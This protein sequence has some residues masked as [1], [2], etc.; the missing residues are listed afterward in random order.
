M[1]AAVHRF[2]ETSTDFADFRRFVPLNLCKSGPREHDVPGGR[3]VDGKAREGE[4]S[5]S[6]N[7]SVEE[8]SVLFL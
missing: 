7:L 8:T 2:Y 4:H 3:W 1:L 6:A 5:R